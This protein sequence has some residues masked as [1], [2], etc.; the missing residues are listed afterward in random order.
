MKRWMVRVLCVIAVGLGCVACSSQPV[1][2]R[3]P[4]TGATAQCGPYFIATPL[5]PALSDAYDK[6]RGC[7]T[8][9]QRLGYER[10]PETIR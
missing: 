7:I 8:D 1:F 10:T 4:Q 5:M 2:L 3:N 6:E 9:F